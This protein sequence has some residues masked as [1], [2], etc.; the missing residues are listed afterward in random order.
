MAAAAFPA[1]AAD[2]DPVTVHVFYNQGIHFLPQDP[3]KYTQLPTT[4]DDNGRT[5]TRTVDI[6]KTGVSRIAAK[7]RFKPIP[8]D[9]V[10]VHDK[11]DRAAY[12]SLAVPGTPGVEVVK[13]MT[14][15]GG[16]TEHE[17]DVTHLAPLLQGSCTFTAFVDTWVSPAWLVDFSLTFYPD[18]SQSPP[19]RVVPLVF[20]TFDEENS[21]G[22]PRKIDV[23]I[24]GQASKSVLHYLV[25]GHCTDG[26][27]ADE[28]E[29]K[30]NVVA[31]DGREVLRY[32]PWRDDC[33]RFRETNPYCRRWSDGSWSADYSRSGWCPS[34]AVLPKVTDLS[35]NLTRGRHT[36]SFNIED[37]RPKKDD[38]LGYWR[39]SA[40]L[41]IWE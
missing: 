20:E 31:V 29:S 18:A 40:Y 41:L 1:A 23:D 2:R 7:V 5:I 35:A 33:I 21:R 14:A 11:W 13:V 30:D 22:E 25:S 37:I 24:P 26:R 4:S 19:A 12:V 15:Y 17:I 6:P 27:G 8:K 10:S 9:E 38:H 39:V 32:K 36:L 28:F 34:D 16:L 3:G